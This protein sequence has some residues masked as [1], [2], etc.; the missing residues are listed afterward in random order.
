MLLMILFQDDPQLNKVIDE[1]DLLKDK[2]GEFEVDFLNYSNSS[3]ATSLNISSISYIKSQIFLSKNEKINS[4]NPSC[5]TSSKNY[6]IVGTFN[7]HILVF[8][9]CSPVSLTDFIDNFP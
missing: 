6:I 1:Q 9:L 7:G 3:S 8:G 2:I 4:G 5:L